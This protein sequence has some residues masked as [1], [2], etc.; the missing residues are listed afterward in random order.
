[1]VWSYPST[2][3]VATNNDLLHS[4]DEVTRRKTTVYR[5]VR[6]RAE[7]L[8]LAKVLYKEFVSVNATVDADN[9]KVRGELSYSDRITKIDVVPWLCWHRGLGKTY[10]LSERAPWSG[11][12]TQG[13]ISQVFST[14]SE[15]D[16]YPTLQVAQ[17]CKC[18]GNRYKLS[19]LPNL[20]YNY[21]QPCSAN[22][23]KIA[24]LFRLQRAGWVFV[25]ISQLWF[26]LL[27][28]WWEDPFSLRL[29]HPWSTC[30]HTRDGHSVLYRVPC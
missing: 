19:Q 10:G 15:K 23:F 28:S 20:M 17:V 27:L 16:V 3:L 2:L 13:S 24:L 29:H 25:D 22:T 14:Q 9:D 26:S 1:M 11:P 5:Q 18:C 8:G 6:R 30:L 7:E 12:A 4:D 21:C